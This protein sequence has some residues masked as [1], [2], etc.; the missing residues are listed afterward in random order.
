GLNSPLAVDVTGPRARCTGQH[1]VD[2]DVLMAE[3]PRATLTASKWG[4]E[5][6]AAPE[7]LEPKPMPAMGETQIA[8]H[9]RAPPDGDY[10]AVMFP[11]WH[12]QAAPRLTA[13]AP[14]VVRAT[15]EQGDDLIFFAGQR[16]VLQAEGVTFA[17]RVGLVRRTKGA[18]TLH[19]LD[20]ISM[21]VP[22]MIAQFPGPVRL[23]IIRPGWIQGD[24]DGA[25][26]TCFLHWTDPPPTP[27]RLMID[28]QD[29]YAYSTFDGYLSFTVPAGRHRFEVRYPQPPQP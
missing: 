15:H 25:A 26:R 7:W 8:L 28:G 10:L 9:T 2:L 24:C 11:Y 1:G 6:K 19:I 4:H 14:G 21:R 16:G 5:G 13:V 29:V 17:G 12:G 23:K 18:V 3:P 22:E 27:A 20:G